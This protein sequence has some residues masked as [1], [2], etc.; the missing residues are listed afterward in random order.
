MILFKAYHAP[1]ILAGKKTQTRRRGKKR[2]IVGHT[3]QAKV[4]Y[5]AKPFAT[6]RVLALRE[7][8][9]S[10]ISDADAIAEGY[11]NRNDY[12][13]AFLNIYGENDPDEVVWVLA[14]ECVPSPQA[15]P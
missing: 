4:S 13:Q 9:L 8:P 1:L 15:A 2:W 12:F 7:E 11:L 5:M 10:H 14:F 6:L 3:H